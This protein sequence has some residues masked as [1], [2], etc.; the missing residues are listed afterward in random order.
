LR[1]TAK[2]LLKGVLVAIIYVLPYMYNL[3]KPYEIYCSVNDKSIPMW[4]HKLIPDAYS[5]I[6]QEY[7]D[8][9]LFN[10]YKPSKALFIF[11]G[12]QGV[13]LMGVWMW[14][15]ITNKSQIKRDVK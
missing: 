9:G 14:L 5:Y 1:E 6:Q 15:W 12:L 2:Y 4:C 10:S 7:W 13:L 8:V 11:F 3:Y